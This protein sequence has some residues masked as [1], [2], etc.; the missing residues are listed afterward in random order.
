MTL[1]RGQ[2]RPSVLSPKRR[3][4][5]YGSQSSPLVHALP[6]AEHYAED[7]SG[8]RAPSSEGIGRHPERSA[9]ENEGCRRDGKGTRSTNA[10]INGVNDA[11]TD[12]RKRST[13]I[14]RRKSRGTMQPGHYDKHGRLLR[15]RR[16]SSLPCTVAACAASSPHGHRQSQLSR[17]R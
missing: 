9:R 5:R 17:C 1:K 7:D 11:T 2:G 10:T 15:R 8:G 4:V 6:P 13:R 12:S 16:S 14:D 3:L